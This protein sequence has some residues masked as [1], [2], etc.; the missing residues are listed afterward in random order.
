VGRGKSEI[1]ISPRKKA[2]EKIQEKKWVF[3]YTEGFV[4]GAKGKGGTGD[5]E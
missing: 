1:H 3:K 2:E 5:E 4:Q